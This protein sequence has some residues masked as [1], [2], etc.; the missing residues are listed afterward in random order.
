MGYGSIF[1]CV[2]PTNL[3][4]DTSKLKAK[5]NMT[6]WQRDDEY[7]KMKT[8]DEQMNNL[9]EE[10]KLYGYLDKDT[11]EGWK[12]YVMQ[13]C[14]QNAIS[15]V[16]IHFLTEENVPYIIGAHNGEFI[17]LE[18]KTMNDGRWLSYVPFD[19]ISSDESDDDQIAINMSGYFDLEKYKMCVKKFDRKHFIFL[20]EYFN[21]IKF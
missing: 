18:A 19:E 1:L 12:E 5:K 2:F 11:R 4:C 14:E 10:M 7:K 21:K 13:I 16:E 20:K 15:D 8:V 6:L 3:K 17:M 9:Y